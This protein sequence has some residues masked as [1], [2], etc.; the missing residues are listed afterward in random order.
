MLND[1]GNN[2][3][4]DSYKLTKLNH[5]FEN[6]SISRRTKLVKQIPVREKLKFDLFTTVFCEI[7]K[8]LITIQRDFD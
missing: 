1:C 8:E 7:F 4:I 3:S 5:K 2:L 6:L